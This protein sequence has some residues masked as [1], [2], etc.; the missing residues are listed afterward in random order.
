[1]YVK[2]LLR[3][4]GFEYETSAFLEWQGVVMSSLEAEGKS[5]FRLHLPLP[6]ASGHPVLGYTS[7]HTSHNLR[8]FGHQGKVDSLRVAYLQGK[9]LKRWE[10]KFR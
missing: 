7:T 4:Q 8:K 2:R 5:P 3:V 10:K 1:M 6:N 9:K